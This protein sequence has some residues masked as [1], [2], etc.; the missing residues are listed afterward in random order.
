MPLLF[1]M[2]SRFVITF[3]PRSKR[4]SISWLQ[5]PS[6][7]ALEPKKIKSVT[8]S[9]VFPSICHEMMGPDAMI[10][11]F[12]ML[13]SKPAFSLSSSSF[14]RGSFLGLYKLISY[15]V[16]SVCY[17]KIPRTEWLIHNRNPLTVQEAGK[18]KIKGPT[19][20]SSREGP[21]SVSSHDE[22][23]KGALW[24]LFYEGAN[25]FNGVPPP[26]LGSFNHFPEVTPPNTITLGISLHEY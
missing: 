19:W 11:V 7:V 8:V 15:N 14:T 26:L 1:N 20:L 5:S 3:L 2:L 25:P 4:L 13:S 23:S 24:L 22:R 12:W 18:S 9:I 6:A 16:P 17:N 21:L 10:F